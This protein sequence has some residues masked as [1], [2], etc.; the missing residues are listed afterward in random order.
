MKCV[1]Y[2]YTTGETPFSLFICLLLGS[3]SPAPVGSLVF[4]YEAARWEWRPRAPSLCPSLKT[5]LFGFPE[6]QPRKR[7]WLHLCR[8]PPPPPPH[9]LY[10][11]PASSPKPPSSRCCCWPHP[12]SSQPDQQCQQQWQPAL[13]RVLQSRRSF[14]AIIARRI[15]AKE[16]YVGRLT[17]CGGFASS[18]RLQS[19]TSPAL[20]VLHPSAASHSQSG[21]HGLSEHSV[22][23]RR[24]LFLFGDQ[25][26]RRPTASGYFRRGAIRCW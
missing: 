26:R 18:G 8:P 15:C 11:T 22:R 21:G 5:L 23:W 19:T 14:T 9:V 1:K 13:H 4:A 6:R 12:P 25:R 16:Q 3:A 24:R 20:T 17:S 10:A 7:T 2:F